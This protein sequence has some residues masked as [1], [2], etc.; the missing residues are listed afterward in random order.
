MLL[1][2]LKQVLWHV[3]HSHA[4]NDCLKYIA[5]C[6]LG[7]SLGLAHGDSQEIQQVK[8]SQVS[9]KHVSPSQVSPEQVAGQVLG[10]VLV[11]VTPGGAVRQH[12]FVL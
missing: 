5:G 9:P 12:S 6:I 10:H 4:S 7:Q 2:I 3:D 11:H 8:S 1:C